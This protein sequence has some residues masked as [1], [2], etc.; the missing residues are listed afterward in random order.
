MEVLSEQ[1]Y[2]SVMIWLWTGLRY[3]GLWTGLV[4]N[5][6]NWI[7]T[8][9]DFLDLMITGFVSVGPLILQ[10]DAL[11]FGHKGLA[12][13]DMIGLNIVCHVFVMCM[14]FWHLVGTSCGL[15]MKLVVTRWRC[16]G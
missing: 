13:F 5:V 9:M 2:V 10:Y 12:C 3:D 7:W 4:M 16:S 8:V 6:W 11:V 15:G 1:S 14:C